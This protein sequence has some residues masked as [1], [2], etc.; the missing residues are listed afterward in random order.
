MEAST[1]VAINGLLWIALAPAASVVAVGVLGSRL[2]DRL[3]PAVGGVALLLGLMVAWL[4]LAG[5]PAPSA[6][7]QGWVPVAA[8]IT[9]AAALLCELLLPAKLR[10]SAVAAVGVLG[11]LFFGFKL[12]APLAG[13]WV[14]GQVLALLS[15]SEWAI[16]ALGVAAL[17]WI[18]VTFAA[19]KVAPPVVLGPLALALAGVALSAALTGSASVAEKVGAAATATATAG[20]FGWRFPKFAPGVVAG[21]AVIAIALFASHAHFYVETPRPGLTLILLAPLGVLAALNVRNTLLAV[22]V[23]LGVTAIPVGAGVWLAF[24]ADAAKQAASGDAGGDDAG[25]Y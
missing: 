4:G 11:L 22:V 18:G 23:A 20:F 6:D 2:P 25:Y 3:R 13:L 1:K 19:R 10:T 8:V 7:A 9:G 14:E 24:Q 15:Q 21:A 5:L 17:T 12:L 16:D